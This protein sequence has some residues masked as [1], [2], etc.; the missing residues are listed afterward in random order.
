MAGAWFVLLALALPTRA[1]DPQTY[2]VRLEGAVSGDIAS[3][4]TASSDL[5]SLRKSAP[6][7]PPG[8]IL[9]ARSDTVRLKNVLEGFGYYQSAVTATIDGDPLVSAD[10][11]DKLA[12]L[13]AGKDA[14]VVVTYVAGP[15]YHLGKITLEGDL[16][17]EM[18]RLLDLR[19]GQ[20]AVALDVI[21]AGTR[22]LRALQNRGYAFAKVVGPIAYEDPQARELNINYT[23]TTGKTAVFG[24]ISVTGLQR[25]RE[26]SVRSRLGVHPGDAFSADAIDKARRNLLTMGVFG[27]VVADIAKAPEADGSVPVTFRVTER[28]RHA[29]VLN[30]NYSTDLGGSGGVTWSDNNLFAHAEQLTV[31]ASIINL[32]GSA[33][34]GV[35]YDTGA[36]LAIPEFLHPQQTL[37]FSL[38]AIQQPLLVYD[39]T[40]ETAG[41][42]LTR[43]LSK[44]WSTSVGFTATEDQIKQP[45]E[46]FVIG[47]LDKTTFYYTL[48]A[49]PLSLRY[50]STDLSSPLLDPTHG[51]R[52]A[53]T[54]TPTLSLGPP[55]ATYVITQ[56]RA[57]AYL[58]LHDFGSLTAP[59]RTVIAV[60]ALYGYAQGASVIDLP[61]DQRFYAGGSGSVR[62]YPFE[63][64]GPQFSDPQYLNTTPQAAKAALGSGF[65]INTPIGGVA[66][67]AASV[68]LRQRVGRN[69]GF[70]VF[71]DAGRVGQTALPFDGAYAVG[72]G[73]GMRY[74][75]PIGPLR[76]DIA[77]PLH[78]LPSPNNAHFEL[79]IGLGQS[80]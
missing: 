42:T 27:T 37:Q 58:D 66:V 5:V 39:Q 61:P 23:V 34:N 50:D 64:V 52:A 30:A 4:L 1:A 72:L 44:I 79:Y 76:F 2:K 78:L 75:T 47:G 57:S 3:T 71:A 28:K 16:P 49:I 6:V 67:D 65:S 59:G 36:R 13:P 48:F 56:V 41:I 77:F 43:D 29:V 9:R 51:M 14:S 7:S 70:A 19:T 40:A 35:G 69:Y 60:H 10:L 8:L 55:N 53:L 80:F 26:S 12:A 54:V 20:P 63:S 18:R 15:L 62:G 24:T 25:T 74:Y 21:N 31:N 45:Q 17:A 73:T 46:Q 32:N 38:T 33:T 68:E 22:L 11:A